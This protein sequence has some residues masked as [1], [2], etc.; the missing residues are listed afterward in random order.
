MP[1]ATQA[2]LNSVVAFFVIQAVAVYIESI[3]I[4]IYQRVTGDAGDGGWRGVVGR[5]WCILWFAATLPLFWD[6]MIA[7]GIMQGN[8]LPK[9]RL[10]SNGEGRAGKFLA[11]VL[12]ELVPEQWKGA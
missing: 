6:P 12:V 1:G 8:F 3:F 11:G 2:G 10:N 4:A 5:V 7:V 9:V